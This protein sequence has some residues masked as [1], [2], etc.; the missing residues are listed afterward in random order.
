MPPLAERRVTSSCWRSITSTAR[1]AAWSLPRRFSKEAVDRLLTYGWPGNAREVERVVAFACIHG[2]GEER[3][4]LAHLPGPI[5]RATQEPVDRATRA[6]LAEWALAKGGER[7]RAA[8]L[9]GVHRNTLDNY[10]RIAGPDVT[11]R[12][13]PWNAQTVE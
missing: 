9:L 12:I 5:V 7:V 1:Q 4:T 8:A 10:R 6:E 2:L 11:R 13:P 3:I